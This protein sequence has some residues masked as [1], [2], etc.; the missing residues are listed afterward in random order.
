MFYR[1]KNNTKEDLR[2]LEKEGY[3]PGDEF[4]ET[5]IVCMFIPDSVIP[6]DSNLIDQFR[7]Y[8]RDGKDGILLFFGHKDF[9][10]KPEG[11]VPPEVGE[12]RRIQTGSRH[13]WVPRVFIQ[14]LCA[15][16]LCEV[17]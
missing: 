14:F 15:I 2:Q 11:K 9:D 3:Y 10:V 13:I 6:A 8:S 1:V 16:T 7:E 4:M 12:V 5:R 17:T